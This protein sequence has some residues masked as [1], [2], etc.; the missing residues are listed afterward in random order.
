MAVYALTING[1]PVTDMTEAEWHISAPQNGAAT[2]DCQF[3]A[4]EEAGLPTF[5]D[6]VILTEDGVPIFGGNILRPRIS[7]I[8]GKGTVE[9][10]AAVTAVDF[11]Q[12][13]SRRYIGPTDI[14][15]GTL[16]AA[17]VVI[18]PW[19][20]GVTLDPTQMDGPVIATFSPTFWKAQEALD[21][22]TQATGY[23][24]RIDASKV[25]KMVVP[26]TVIAPF[27]VLEGDESSFGDITVEPKRDDY[28]NRVFVS[29]P[30]FGATAEDPSAYT[31]PWELFVEAELADLAAAQNLADMILAAKLPVLKQIQY[32]T[33]E[34]GLEVG[35]S[36]MVI[37]PSRGIA[38]AFLIT[39]IN[40]DYVGGLARRTVTAIEGLVYRTG[41]REN[42]RNL[43][44][45][46]G[47]VTYGAGGGGGGGG[48]TNTRYAYP[49]GG[50]EGIFVSSPVP[51]WVDATPNAVQ[52]STVA[53]GTTS[54]T[55]V[56][57]LRALDPG[58]SVQA[59]L[60]DVSDGVALP[61]V[62]AVVTSTE[63]QTVTWTVTLNP[64]AHFVKLQVLSGVAGAGV[65][66]V[67][68]LE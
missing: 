20:P 18:V 32:T 36:Q 12:L 8:A 68:Y 50:A 64:G 13:A 46:G 10:I 2:L 51:T 33:L 37:L 23:L 35:M 39:E 15:E 53:R 31:E 66:A 57:Q 56:A 26:G 54:A 34:M 9:V 16:K 62:S 14:P 28:A 60:F 48:S 45:G 7:G 30:T 59:R 22:L 49:L 47:H 67:G 24:W 38:N 19:I 5:D 1:V 61:G 55:V 65:A 44:G 40:T 25:L 58:V 4:D 6:D 29:T 11:N 41:W 17:L 42:T 43:F 63:W 52:V 21:Y 27:D 3:W